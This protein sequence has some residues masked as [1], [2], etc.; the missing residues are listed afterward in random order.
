MLGTMTKKLQNVA[1]FVDTLFANFIPNSSMFAIAVKKNV[2][3]SL[4]K[5]VYCLFIIHG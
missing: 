5:T 2:S 3:N 1:N 4:L